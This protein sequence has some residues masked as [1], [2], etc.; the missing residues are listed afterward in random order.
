MFNEG[1]C[2]QFFTEF[3]QDDDARQQRDVTRTNTHICHVTI[4]T[5]TWKNDPVYR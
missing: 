2:C 3:L 1:D 5:I 4:L